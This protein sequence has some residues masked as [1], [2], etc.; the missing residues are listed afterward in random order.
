MSIIHFKGLQNFQ[1][2]VVLR[3]LWCIY[4]LEN[5][6][7]TGEMPRSWTFH[8]DLHCFSKYPLKSFSIQG[9][10]YIKFIIQLANIYI[11]KAIL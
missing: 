8:R 11:F 3:S 4:I 5:S 2:Y 10:N 6:V 9:V 1:N 7:D